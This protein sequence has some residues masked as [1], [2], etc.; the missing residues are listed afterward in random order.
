MRRIAL[1]AAVFALPTLGH[2][3]EFDGEKDTLS[4]KE[5]AEIKADQSEAQKAIEEKY[6]DDNSSEGRLAKQKEIQ[7]SEQDIAQRHGVSTRT[8]MQQTVHTSADE[9]REV[10]EQSKS[11]IEERSKKK[12]QPSGKAASS[13]GPVEV[14]KGFSDDKPVDLEGGTPAKP[15]APKLDEN[16]QPLPTIEKNIKPDDA[17]AAIEAA[18]QSYASKPH[19]NSG[20]SKRK[21]KSNYDE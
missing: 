17:S 1:I 10:D 18:E 2:A 21:K 15:E 8:L 20:H 6:K 9:Q 12:A 7:Q 5:K 14:V 16:G 19:S 13:E 4:T 11:I 3:D